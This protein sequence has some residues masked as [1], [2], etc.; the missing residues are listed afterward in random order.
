MT[1]FLLDTNVVSATAPTK[2]AAESA[3]LRWMSRHGSA[4]Y[5][6][7]VTIAEI[8]DGVLQLDRTAPGKRSRSLLDWVSA[9]LAIYDD[10]ILPVDLTVARETARLSD[11]ARSRGH[12]PG[13]ADTLIA[14][15][16]ARYR[17]TIA[18]RNVRHFRSFELP[19]VDPCSGRPDL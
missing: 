13:L 4:S 1:G 3:L 8:E 11:V 16:A 17:L 14:A 2:G 19:I 7:V 5:L 18:T 9:L 15:T 12:D 6:S 10:R